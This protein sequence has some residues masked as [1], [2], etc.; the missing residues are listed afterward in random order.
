MDDKLFHKSA[1]VGCL[2]SLHNDRISSHYVSKPQKTRLDN[3]VDNQSADISTMS[4]RSATIYVIGILV[5]LVAVLSR[6]GVQIGDKQM[7]SDKGQNSACLHLQ[8]MPL[9]N[10]DRFVGS[11]YL[12]AQLEVT[13]FTE[14]EPFCLKA[15]FANAQKD[16]QNVQFTFASLNCNSTEETT[17]TSR[18]FDECQVQDIHKSSG[19]LAVNNNQQGDNSWKVLQTDYQNIAVVHS[20]QNL[21]AGRVSEYVFVLG[22][23]VFVDPMDMGEIMHQLASWGLPYRQVQFTPHN[24]CSKVF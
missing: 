23:S 24:L 5:A 21:I 15:D 2:A 11:W 3:N 7:M 9:F 16:L 12:V 17:G 13:R 20:C 8:E 4:R 10:F 14:F 22:R 1:S 19:N 18:N 6:G